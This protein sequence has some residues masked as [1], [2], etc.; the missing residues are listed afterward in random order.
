M[1]DASGG[2]RLGTRWARI[3]AG[4]VN[5]STEPVEVGDFLEEVTALLAPVA[6]AD[7]QRLRQAPSTSAAMP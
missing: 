3:E 5:R 1:R 7:R 2:Q 4:P 6:E